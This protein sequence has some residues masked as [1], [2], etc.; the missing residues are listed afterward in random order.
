MFVTKCPWHILY[1]VRIYNYIVYTC[2]C[3][4]VYQPNIHT[5]CGKSVYLSSI[6]QICTMSHTHVIVLS[7]WRRVCLAMQCWLY[8]LSIATSIYCACRGFL[9]APQRTCTSEAEAYYILY[10]FYMQT[11]KC[12]RVCCELCCVVCAALCHAPNVCSSFNIEYSMCH[13]HIGGGGWLTLL[14]KY[15]D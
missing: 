6:L 7:Q 3:T 8:C 14:L 2:T 15:L 13:E 11:C 10:I 12:M 9:F 4:T 5:M 1:Y